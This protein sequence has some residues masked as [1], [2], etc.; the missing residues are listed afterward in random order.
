[1]YGYTYNP[2]TYQ[3]DV[4]PSRFV[5]MAE[6]LPGDVPKTF[7]NMGNLQ[8]VKVCSDQRMI[9][10]WVIEFL[11]KH[12]N[13][14]VTVDEVCEATQYK[15]EAMKFILRRL[16]KKGLLY[17]FNDVFCGQLRKCG[18]HNMCLLCPNE[19]KIDGCKWKARP[20]HNQIILVKRSAIKFLED[21]RQ[22][23]T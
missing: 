7:L 11:L 2:D 5:V 4:D 13:R 3:M 18:P 1:M 17:A 12:T 21:I 23:R 16:R 19:G 15:K 20:L 9:Y 6:D 8:E 10:T 22:G 14:Q